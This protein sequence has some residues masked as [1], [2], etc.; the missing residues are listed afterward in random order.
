MDAIKVG[1]RVRIRSSKWR[2]RMHIRRGMVGTVNL[3]TDSPYEEFSI[4][5]HFNDSLYIRCE[6]HHLEKVRWTR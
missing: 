2:A 4:T 5:V 3:V 1:D 6:S